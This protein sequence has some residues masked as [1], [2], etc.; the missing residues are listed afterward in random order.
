MVDDEESIRSITKQTLEAFNY[1]AITAEDG[2][3]AIAIYAQH[4][5]EV[6][7]VLTDVMMPV[8]DGIAL[9]NALRRMNSG[10]PI[11]AAS[12]HQENLSLDRISVLGI[13]HV[14]TKPYSAETL[15]VAIHQVLQE[16]AP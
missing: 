16:R 8:M 5:D 2:A 4:R 3:S 11:V 10:L 14:L 13:A 15:L 6:A 12:G 1:R 9:A 7:L